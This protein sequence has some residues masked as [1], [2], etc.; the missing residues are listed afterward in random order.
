MEP[1]PRPAPSRPVSNS[2]LVGL[3]MMPPV[4]TYETTLTIPR[5]LEETF[6]FVSDFRNAAKWDPRTYSAEKTTDGPIGV[7]TRFMLTGGIMPESVVKRLHL[8]KSVAGMSLP[9]DVVAFDAPNEFTLK[10]ESRML[11]WC[12]CLEFTA[13]G[14]STSLRYLAELEMKRFNAPGEALLHRMFQR[15]GDGATAD[16]PATVA[17]ET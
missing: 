14:D 7:G 13:V 4:A 12:D 5:P 16:L 11:R 3:C 2:V 10:G 9:Y 15:I 17:R 8:P 6:A 1:R